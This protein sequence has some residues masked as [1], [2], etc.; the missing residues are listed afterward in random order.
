MLAMLRIATNPAKV[1]LEPRDVQIKTKET[2][3]FSAEILVDKWV[4]LKAAAETLSISSRDFLHPVLSICID[5]IRKIGFD[6]G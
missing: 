6:L 2:F 3:V 4:D 1:G 5:A